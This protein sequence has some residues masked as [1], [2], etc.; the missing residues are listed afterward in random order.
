MIEFARTGKIDADFVF[1]TLPSEIFLE[2]L[3]FAGKFVDSLTFFP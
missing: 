2:Y 1:P 3:L